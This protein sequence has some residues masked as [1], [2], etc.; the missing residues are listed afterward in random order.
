MI[1]TRKRLISI[2]VLY[3][4]AMHLT[5]AVLVAN[6][7]SAMNATAVN[8]LYKYIPN[9]VLLSWVLL[10]VAGSAMVGLFTRVPWIVLLLI[11]QQLV[12]MASAAG[13]IEAI[14][15]AHFA[16]LVERSR[17]FIAADQC[18]SILAAIGHTIAIVAHA[19][20][21]GGAAADSVGPR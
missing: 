11:P 5:W 4:I 16:D 14:W 9:A 15:L 7:P 19:R 8:A 12:L 21:V 2:M 10:G 20:Q 13:A 3:A 17:A 18:Y 6:D 1:R